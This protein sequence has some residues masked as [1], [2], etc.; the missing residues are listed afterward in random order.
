[1]AFCLINRYS[2]Q[3]THQDIIDAMMEIYRASSTATGIALDQQKITIHVG[4][5]GT[6]LIATL[7]PSDSRDVIKWTSDDEKVATVNS[8]GL[9]TAVGAGT[10][11]I[12]AAI[13]RRMSGN[14]QSDRAKTF[15]YTDKAVYVRYIRLD[16]DR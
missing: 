10:C 13:L 16:D 12:T 11:T 7:T 9:V 14:V 4:D 15:L 2:C 5:E 6:Q 3:V 1:M 8:N